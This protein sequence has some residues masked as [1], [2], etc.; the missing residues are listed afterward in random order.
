M[1][2]VELKLYGTEY[3][4]HIEGYFSTKQIEYLK[5]ITSKGNYIEVGS[6]YN[7]SRCKKFEIPIKNNEIVIG[8]SGFID[9]PYLKK[10]NIFYFLLSQVYSFR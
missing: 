7:F 3:I 2:H 10:G 1:Q 6:K 8:F 9:K 4:S 5:V